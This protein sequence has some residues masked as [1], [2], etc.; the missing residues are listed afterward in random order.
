VAGGDDVFRQLVL[1]RIIGPASKLDSLRVLDEAGNRC[2]S[3][4]AG[5]CP[6]YRKPIDFDRKSI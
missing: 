5:P 6:A 1:A 4:H 2:S 3:L